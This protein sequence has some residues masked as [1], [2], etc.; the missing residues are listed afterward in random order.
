[1]CNPSQN[2][3][4]RSK[5]RGCTQ[6]E[7]HFYHTLN[8]D[9]ERAS[10]HRALPDRLQDQVFLVVPRAERLEQLYDLVPPAL[11]HVIDAD[12]A[13]LDVVVQQKVE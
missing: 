11:A 9:N 1:V 2:L 6:T 12:R 10:L 7:D 3:Q 13:H 4:Y 5:V 8:G